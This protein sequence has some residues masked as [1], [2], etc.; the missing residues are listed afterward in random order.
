MIHA[1]L[2]LKSNLALYIGAHH[3]HFFHFL[4]SPTRGVKE[5]RKEAIVRWNLEA[6][7]G[8]ANCIS[9]HLSLIR[10]YTRKSGSQGL[11]I[12]LVWMKEV[13]M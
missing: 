11:D 4:A 12:Q 10:F 13:G 7:A 5:I 6:T 9:Q 1:S 2:K 3:V 8:G